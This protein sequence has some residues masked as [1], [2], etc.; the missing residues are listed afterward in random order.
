MI[1]SSPHSAPK[2]SVTLHNN[3]THISKWH[4]TLHCCSSCISSAVLYGNN[5]TACS[6]LAIDGGLTVYGVEGMDGCPGPTAA[7]RWGTDSPSL[8]GTLL[9]LCPTHWT[10][11]LR[12]P[13]LRCANPAQVSTDPSRAQWTQYLTASRMQTFICCQSMSNFGEVKVWNVICFFPRFH[14]LQTSGGI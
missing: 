14:Q 11:D 3:D 4:I 13:R 12:L 5:F 7:W 8:W 2:S 1:S 10:I 6:V 9:L